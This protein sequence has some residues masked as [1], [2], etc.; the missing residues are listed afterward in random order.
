V[1]QIVNL[2][3]KILYLVVFV[4]FE[5]GEHLFKDQD[6]RLPFVPLQSKAVDLSLH[7]LFS[8]LISL[9]LE[10]CG[11]GRLKP[12][13]CLIG[14]KVGGYGASLLCHGEKVLV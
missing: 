13:E 6:L 5:V 7:G 14:G 3:L 9:E 2:L 12:A 11:I 1:L 8:I 10:I 4:L